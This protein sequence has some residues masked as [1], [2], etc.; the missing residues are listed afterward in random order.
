[1]PRNTPRSPT[2]L[3][4]RK[5]GER[6]ADRQPPAP[7]P[8]LS[9]G[10]SLCLAAAPACDAE[11]EDPGLD[12]QVQ[13]LIDDDVKPAVLV[14]A[15]AT[16]IEVAA[17]PLY[18]TLRA[19]RPGEYTDIEVAWIGDRRI[20]LR[21]QR[22]QSFGEDFHAA[23]VGADGRGHLEAAPLLAF[24]GHRR[25][26]P[27]YPVSVLVSPENVAARIADD[28]GTYRVMPRLGIDD[29]GSTRIATQ[30]YLVEER[31]Q[32][33]ASAAIKPRC[34]TAEPE[35]GLDPDLGEPS[36]ARAGSCW[37]IEIRAHG[38]YEY[39]AWHTGKDYNL[40]VFY[41]AVVLH[42]ASAP[43][44]SINL[45]L[46]VPEGGIVILTSPGNS[47]YYPKSWSAELL[48]IETR[49]FWNFFLGGY[50]RD[51]ALLFTGKDLV[52]N[53]VGMAYTGSVCDKPEYAYGV[54]QSHPS[55]VEITAHEIGHALGA[56]HSDA[57]GGGIMNSWV[58]GST[59]FVKYSRDQMNWHLWFNGN[60]CLGHAECDH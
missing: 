19:V 59:H 6:S 30:V 31:E 44:A 28:E 20:P 24:R 7:A 32:A 13:A 17:E 10:L 25:D 50:N 29:D 15:I 37:Q 48:L 55:A 52:G 39:Y 46:K 33:F 12:G 26:A 4:I 47:L 23:L 56:S 54:V 16:E 45:D 51:L 43:Y 49:K 36:S 38:D 27:E 57:H 42:E 1:M 11:V 3:D 2:I 41:I 53:H 22:T 5:C 34:G 21:L 9:V 14:D 40:A 8:R 35:V 60:K 18:E 58:N